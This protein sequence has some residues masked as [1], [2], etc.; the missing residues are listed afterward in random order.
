MLNEENMIQNVFEKTRENA[1]LDLCLTQ[2]VDS[3]SD[4]KVHETFS[5]S[6]YSY[7][8][9]KFNLPINFPRKKLHIEISKTSITSLSG[10]I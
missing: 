1:I 7:I 6:D 2:N 9:S 4:L 8:T 3:I 10:L 5:T